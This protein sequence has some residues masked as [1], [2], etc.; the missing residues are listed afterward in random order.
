M[1]APL[2][3]LILSAPVKVAVMPVTSGEGVP[4]KTAEAV[5]GAVTAEVRKRSGGQVITQQEITTLLSLE[6]QKAMMGCQND[7]CFAELGGALGVDRVVSGD[8]SRLGES[9]LFHLKLLDP[10]KAQVLVTSDRR[11]RG[12]TIDDVLDALPAMVGELSPPA[13]RPARSA[14]ATATP[15]PSASGEAK[16]AKP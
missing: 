8:L 12:G 10:A 14:A 2:L 3:A 4:G 7:A 13:A 6:Q 16:G 9:W 5:T 1:L 11:L 15:P